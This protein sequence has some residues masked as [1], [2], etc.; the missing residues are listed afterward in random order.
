MSHC[1]KTRK[2]EINSNAK[3]RFFKKW[4]L[5]MNSC[6]VFLW[7][8]YR[9]LYIL[10]LHFLT[11]VCTSFFSSNGSLLKTIKDSHLFFNVAFNSFFHTLL[12]NRSFVVFIH[13]NWNVWTNIVFEYMISFRRFSSSV[14]AFLSSLSPLA[15]LPTNIS[16]WTTKIR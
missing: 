3:S 9:T 11:N 2:Y 12:V 1:Y 4:T 15:F 10:Y 16:L 5:R 6:S 13:R 7:L 8:L 14:L